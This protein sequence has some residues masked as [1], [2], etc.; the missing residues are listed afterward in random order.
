MGVE[1]VPKALQVGYKRLLELDVGVAALI[2]ECVK[3][4]L[5]RRPT[6]TQLVTRLMMVRRVVACIWILHVHTL[7]LFETRV[8][9]NLC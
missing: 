8:C 5:R 2:A 9:V 6:S 7:V 4:D 3:N 1:A